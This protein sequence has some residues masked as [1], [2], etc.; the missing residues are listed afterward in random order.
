VA[1]CRARGPR[2]SRLASSAAAA[3][4]GCASGPLGRGRVV[5]GDLGVRFFDGSIF[6]H[7]FRAMRAGRR[8]RATVHG[9]GAGVM[10]QR[11]ASRRS[12]GACARLAR[13]LLLAMCLFLVRDSV[14]FLCAR[15]P[16]TFAA[17]APRPTAGTCGG[18][19]PLAA[20]SSAAMVAGLQRLGGG[21][22]ERSYLIWIFSALARAGLLQCRRPARRRLWRSAESIGCVGVEARCL[23]C[24]EMWFRVLALDVSRSCGSRFRADREWPLV[25]V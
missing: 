4:R 23:R 1:R 2:I 17:V 7:R 21:C 19:T 13:R 16:V 12:L 6:W 24:E 14:F 18:S 3:S 22:K 9:G 10:R 20:V 5:I 25:S 8:A 15:L 11:R